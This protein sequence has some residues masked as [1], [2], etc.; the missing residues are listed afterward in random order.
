MSEP[1]PSIEEYG[2]ISDC[3]T[4]AF[5]SRAGSLDWLCLPRFDSGSSFGR[6]LD[7]ERG[8]HFS[9]HPSDRGDLSVHCAY[10]ENTL[11]LERIFRVEGGEARVLD[12]MTMGREGPQE[13]PPRLLSVIEGVRGSIEFEIE[14]VPR[15]DYGEVDPW[16][17]HQG[18][19]VYTAIGGDDGLVIHSDAELEADRHE[20][21]SRCTVKPGERIRT[22]VAFTDPADAR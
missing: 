13:D 6:L 10:L 12:C 14:I 18:R 20:L 11:V 3:Q 16:I 19:G 21:R 5:V 7:W 2:L 4:A 17:R 9:I 15:F 1:Y 8:G 22:S